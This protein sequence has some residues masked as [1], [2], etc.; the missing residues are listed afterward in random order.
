M[1]SSSAYVVDPTGG[2]KTKLGNEET[3]LSTTESGGTI[4]RRYSRKSSLEDMLKEKSNSFDM[5]KEKG[6]CNKRC[7]YN[8]IFD[9]WD[10][11]CYMVVKLGGQLS[12]KIPCL[13]S[14]RDGKHMSDRVEGAHVGLAVTVED[15]TNLIN[16]ILLMSALF[17]SFV[18]GSATILGDEQNLKYDLLYC[19]RGWAHGDM[20]RDLDSAGYFGDFN[21]T[22]L[23]PL[24][25][26][27]TADR[28]LKGQVAGTQAVIDSMAN[29]KSV[30]IPA[31]FFGLLGKSTHFTSAQDIP[32][33]AI[34][35]YSVISIA[36]LILVVMIGFVQYVVLVLSGARSMGDDI[37]Q[38]YWESGIILVFLQILFTIAAV[39]FW[40]QS[41]VRILGAL[42]PSYIMH[43]ME[44][45]Y[46]THFDSDG[47]F[48]LFSSA[49]G[50]EGIFCNGMLLV[51]PL[52]TFQIFWTCGTEKNNVLLNRPKHIFGFVM[53]SLDHLENDD[54]LDGEHKETATVRVAEIFKSLGYKIGGE[55]DKTTNT[56]LKKEEQDAMDEMNHFIDEFQFLDWG[57]LSFKDKKR[58][59]SIREKACLHRLFAELYGKD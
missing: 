40:G 54:C 36:L 21:V 11:W 9:L 35:F 5:F 41:L 23:Q 17:L 30:R 38:A 2:E 45:G 20:C 16:T 22:G 12:S 52:V 39:C 26:D 27:V 25:A 33:F 34:M 14:C 48:S 29:S 42:G 7:C 19:Q 50:L 32:S 4:Q 13:R 18:A 37:M 3:T 46:V 55:I 28:M 51:G 49:I 10:T 53:K 47:D 15:F 43:G 58:V 6:H 24:S 1:S 31:M 59:L 8:V 44:F 56:V 57:A